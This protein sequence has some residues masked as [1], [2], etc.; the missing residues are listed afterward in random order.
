M[1]SKL[2]QI[3]VFPAG[4]WG[5]ARGEGTVQNLERRPMF[6]VSFVVLVVLVFVYL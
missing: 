6:D 1:T 5:R 2:T 4:T 3:L